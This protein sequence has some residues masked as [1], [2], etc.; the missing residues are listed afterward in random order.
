MIAPRYAYTEETPSRTELD[1]PED[2]FV[3]ANFNHPCKFEP[4]IFSA[5]MRILL[6]IPNAVLWCG[7]WIDATK[8]NLRAEAERQGVA[9]SRLI[10]SKQVDRDKHCARLA[11][12]DLALDTYYHGGGITSVDAL[13]AGIPLLTVRGTTPSSRM[14]T[15]LLAAVGM[16][17]LV[18]TDLKEYEERAVHLAGTPHE[19]EAI[20]GR[21]AG[22]LDSS[23]LFDLDRYARNL[24]RAYHLMWNAY[25]DGTGP[26]EIKVP[27]SG[28]LKQHR[29]AS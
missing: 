18:C 12:A 5:W 21:L 10:F 9:A 13:S 3:M 25:L 29:W 15:T 16:R 1:L 26:K 4:E 19:L 28:D 27:E 6:R 2:A 20:R 8:R 23:P 17:D 14:G 11:R 7:A 24:E 22:G